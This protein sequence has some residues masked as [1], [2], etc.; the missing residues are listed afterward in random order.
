M[1]ERTRL[2][3]SFLAVARRC[4]RRADQDEVSAP[5][6]V[7]ATEAQKIVGREKTHVIRDGL[8]VDL[9][10]REEGDALLEAVL[11]AEQGRRDLLVL[12][13][14]I[15]K[16]AAGADLERGRVLVLS[17]VKLDEIGDEALDLGPVEVGRRVRVGEVQCG[18]T[19]F[20][21]VSLLERIAPEREQID[22]PRLLEGLEW[23]ER[24]KPRGAR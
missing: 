3:A 10:E 4:R 23:R 24:H 13:D 14:D 16:L 11:V 9:V 17:F 15:V 5:T 6:G 22:Q 18:Q 21:S 8:S 1:A 7:R 12:D 19:R 20:Q 2:E